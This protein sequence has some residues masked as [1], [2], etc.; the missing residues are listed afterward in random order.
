[1]GQDN[2]EAYG[3]RNAIKGEFLVKIRPTKIIAQKDIAGW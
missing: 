3:K 2:A 1:M